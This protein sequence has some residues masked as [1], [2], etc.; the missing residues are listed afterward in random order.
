M[1]TKSSPLT[2]S[3]S[4]TANFGLLYV[5][6]AL[7]IGSR[8]LVHFN[9]IEHPT[10]EVESWAYRRVAIARSEADRQCSLQTCD[11]HYTSRMPELS[12]PV[13]RLAL[14]PDPA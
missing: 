5:F 12:D 7:E 11:W 6:V 2:S 8:R 9:V 1:P 3:F 14:A 4:V 13:Q 10:E